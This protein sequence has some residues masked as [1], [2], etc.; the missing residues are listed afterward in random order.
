MT[1]DDAR[2]IATQAIDTWPNGPKG[3]VWQ[4]EIRGCDAE[5]ARTAMARLRRETDRATTA[6]FHAVYNAVRSTS[7]VL[8]APAMCGQCNGTGWI[9]ATALEAH[10]PRVC[11]A[12]AGD[13][14]CGCHAVK[15]C[16]CSNAHQ[17]HVVLDLI[18]NERKTP[19]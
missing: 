6:Q 14:G 15:P 18:H 11:A 4:N 13:M 9:E 17:A 19:A 5:L 10:E 1:D 3:Y 2:K 16:R 7:A 8:T 12:A